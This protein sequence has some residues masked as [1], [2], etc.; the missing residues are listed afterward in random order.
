MSETITLASRLAGG[1]WGHLIGDA[2]GVPYEFTP[3]SAIGEV[4]F[5]KAGGPWHQPAG[6]WSDDGALMLALLDSLLHAGFDPDD[7][8]R[9]ALA[10]ADDGAYTPDGDGKFDIG[11]TTSAA[12]PALRVGARAVEAGPTDEH[13]AGNGSLMRN[14]PLA[15]V[16]RAPRSRPRDPARTV[17]DGDLVLHAH[18]ASRVTHGNM[19]CQVACA[20][21]SLLVRRLLHGDQPA[22]ALAAARSCSGRPTRAT[23][24]SRT[25]SLPSTRSRRGRRAP[26]AATWSTASGRRGTRS[27]GRRATRRRSSG[28]CGTATIRTRRRRSRAGSRASTGDGRASRSPGEGGC[29]ARGG[30]AARGRARRD[31]RKLVPEDAHEHPLPLKL[32]RIDLSGTGGAEA[33][34]SS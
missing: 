12:M 8:G 20:L 9:R 27:R 28:R 32:D 21:Y 3:P 26:D 13:A 1:I 25:I 34:R 7:Q 16:E 33:G 5:G 15:L 6:T 31:D 10:W 19:Q 30:H 24:R 2:T 11:G 29:A 18:A 4:V 22:D 14:L 23:G 17:R